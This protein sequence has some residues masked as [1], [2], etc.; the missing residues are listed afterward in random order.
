M[1]L[2]N[3]D[4]VTFGLGIKDILTK[5]VGAGDDKFLR[6]EEIDRI[7]AD[8]V[9]LVRRSKDINQLYTE[10][11]AVVLDA[12][13]RHL[14]PGFGENLSTNVEKLQQIVDCLNQYITNIFSNL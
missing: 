13:I 6:R 5:I 8:L 14:P 7:S 10:V 4:E 3:F 2:F 11:Y 12:V 9:N 1:T